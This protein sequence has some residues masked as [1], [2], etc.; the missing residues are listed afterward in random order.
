MPPG[1]P[2]L[3]MIYSQWIQCET[4]HGDGHSLAEGLLQSDAL[5][6]TRDAPTDDGN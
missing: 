6:N 4:T 2:A 1:E 5:R 3:S